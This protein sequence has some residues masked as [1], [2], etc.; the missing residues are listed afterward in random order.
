MGRGG[1][2]PLL[3]GCEVTSLCDVT[4]WLGQVRG[5]SGACPQSAGKGPQPLGRMRV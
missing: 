4:A 1:P 5:R 2:Q 3:E